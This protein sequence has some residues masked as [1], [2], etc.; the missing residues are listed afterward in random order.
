MTTTFT[1]RVR[2][3]FNA[4]ENPRTRVACVSEILFARLLAKAQR[5]LLALGLQPEVFSNHCADDVEDAVVHLCSYYMHD[6]C[7]SQAYVNHPSVFE[8]LAVF[9]KLSPAR[10][11]EALLQCNGEPDRAMEV[12]FKFLA[13]ERLPMPSVQSQLASTTE[14]WAVD[15]FPDMPVPLLRKWSSFGLPSV[16][17][18]L[19][20]RSVAKR[21]KTPRKHNPE[22]RVPWPWWFVTPVISRTDNAVPAFQCCVCLAD[23]DADACVACPS[24]DATHAACRACVRAYLINDLY[25]NRNPKS[26]C[27]SGEAACVGSYCMTDL[28]VVLG[29]HFSAYEAALAVR[30]AKDVLTSED[31]RL[32]F[33]LCGNFVECPATEPGHDTTKETFVPQTCPNCGYEFCGACMRQSHPFS[34]SCD[35]QVDGRILREE[36]LTDAVVCTCPCGIKFVKTSGC[37]KVSCSC[38]RKMCYVCRQVIR[39]YEHFCKCAQ[40][41]S[42]SMCHLDG[43]YGQRAV[44]ARL[45]AAESI[46]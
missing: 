36:R 26:S 16:V 18:C 6:E 1:Q 35:E 23:A 10:V 5:R 29:V 21:L 32:F 27:V 34:K 28:K 31:G 38:G 14:S 25:V 45:E 22:S 42:C 19:A 3:A 39:G 17:S 33:C 2:R 20:K 46:E 4:F 7:A 13:L 8:V 11:F 30:F 15:T 37:N 44:R 24:A 43:S 9:H 40:P 41:Q 12:C